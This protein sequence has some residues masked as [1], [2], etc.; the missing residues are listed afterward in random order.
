MNT[1]AAAS[2]TLHP[3]GH[4]RTGLA[5]RVEAPRQ[6]RAARG[7]AGRIELLPGHHYEHA[8]EDLDAWQYLWVLFW[9]DRNANW[10]PKVLPPRS[11]SGRKGVFATRAPHRPNPLGLSVVR[12]ERIEGLTLHIRDVDMLDGTPV[13]DIKPY[14]AYTDAIIDAGAGWLDD[15]A[16]AADPAAAWSV[17]WSTLAAGQAAW[18]EARTGLPL[19]Q[20]A[21]AA[22]TLGPEPHP[23]RR[24]R[25]SD[26]GGVLAVKAWRL[27]FAVSGRR[28]QIEAV[29]C[30]YRAA[31]LASADSRVVDRD[32]HLAFRAQW[33]EQAD[34]PCL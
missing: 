1:S 8:I 24:I 18:I 26:A 14:V 19:A 23:Y 9:F 11:R 3:I 10:R 22:L 28:V 7:V 32:A 34:A 20:R 16:G 15:A 25:R 33:P 21:T 31:Q 29:H 17:E 6:P 5:T 13:L 27:R 30:G 2:L 12:L 4:V